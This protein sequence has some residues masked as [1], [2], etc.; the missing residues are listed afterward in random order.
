METGTTTAADETSERN[1][2]LM[3]PIMKVNIDGIDLVGTMTGM[4][5]GVQ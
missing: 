5:E 3:K 4:E 1:P 2:V